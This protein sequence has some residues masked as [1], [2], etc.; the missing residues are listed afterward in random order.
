MKKHP[1]NTPATDL[2]IYERAV[3][4]YPHLQHVKDEMHFC[5]QL[6]RLAAVDGISVKEYF[7]IATVA[8]GCMWPE[9]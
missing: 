8:N 6:C 5:Q 9:N 2:P 7:K 3:K 1:A 4:R